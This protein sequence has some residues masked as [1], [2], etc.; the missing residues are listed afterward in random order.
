MK[1]SNAYIDFADLFSPNLMSK[2]SEYTGIN[3]YAIKLFAGQPLLYRPIYSQRLVELETLKAYIG[4]NLANRSIK[5]SQSPTDTSIFFN[6]KLD[7]FFY[8]CVIYRSLNNLTVKNRY[9]LL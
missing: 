1:V 9:P 6:Q 2:L 5:L 4:T 7:G 3:D 8:L